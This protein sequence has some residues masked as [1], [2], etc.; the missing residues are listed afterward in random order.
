[1]QTRRCALARGAVRTCVCPVHV[2]AHTREFWGVGCTHSAWGLAGSACGWPA[3]M[4]AL[5]CCAQAPPDGALPPCHLL[6][7]QTCSLRRDMAGVHEGTPPSVPGRAPHHSQG[8]ET[9]TVTPACANASSEI[10]EVDQRLGVTGGGGFAAGGG[11]VAGKQAQLGKA[12][13][14]VYDLGGWAAPPSPIVSTHFWMPMPPLQR[15]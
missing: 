6:G 1:M 13:G 7:T 9:A 2:C 3:R 11:L 8:R 14:S 4:W 10:K 15:P 12:A 5:V